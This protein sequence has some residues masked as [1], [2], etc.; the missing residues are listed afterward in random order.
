MSVCICTQPTSTERFKN[1]EQLGILADERVSRRAIP[2]NPFPWTVDYTRV[3]FKAGHTVPDPTLR[4]TGS[5]VRDFCTPLMT[6]KRDMYTRMAAPF[7]IR[8]TRQI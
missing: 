8:K 7:F 1:E 6:T 2:V 5:S 3:L 4:V